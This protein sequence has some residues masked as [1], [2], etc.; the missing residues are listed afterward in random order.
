[1]NK[2]KIC[3]IIILIVNFGYILLTIRNDLSFF[4]FHS[5]FNETTYFLYIIL[6]IVWMAALL[7]SENVF[8]R[9]LKYRD[10]YNYKCYF[11]FAIILICVYL[12]SFIILFPGGWGNVGDEFLLYWAS[13]N[14]WIWPQQGALSGILM[15]I[16][17][18][19]WP[20]SWMIALIQTFV[21][22]L[23]FSRICGRLYTNNHKITS[24]LGLVLFCSLPCLS[25][26]SNYMRNWI[27]AICFVALMIEYA[28]CIEKRKV[29]RNQIIYMSLLFIFIVAI[30]TETKF[31]FFIYPF[32]LYFLISRCSCYW[33]NSKVDKTG[34]RI[35]GKVELIAVLI[36]FI[37]STIYSKF[38]GD[39]LKYR[40]LSLV[41]FVCPLS[42]ILADGSSNLKGLDGDIEN[43]DTV[44]P[45]SDLVSYPS[46]EL[47][48]QN[49][50]F[51]NSYD[52]CDRREQM[53]FVRSAIKIFVKNYKRYLY[54]R[55]RMVRAS[56]PYG[57]IQP[58]ADLEHIRI[59]CENND[60]NS[61][62]LWKD[63]DYNNPIRVK[64]SRI[65]AGHDIRKGF[66]KIVLLQY[67]YYIPLLA[68]LLTLIIS[69]IRKKNSYIVILSP[70][71]I[72]FI[73]LFFFVPNRSHIYFTVF[74]ITGWMIIANIVERIVYGILG[75]MGSFRESFIQ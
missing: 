28:L 26:N 29:N 57:G 47:F 75:L 66:R 21:T 10:N 67:N 52:D 13:K 18:M 3:L 19:F 23:I 39:Y 35:I 16:C 74:Y 11:V 68:I 65:L 44:F 46:D 4:D 2:R 71:L 8:Y 49:K 51:I 48:W 41:S 37:I 54:S 20:K 69:T 33:N 5:G 36:V 17:L 22:C 24:I 45:V 53:N 70:I 73:A 9:L 27:T 30:R 64:C 42:V 50:K 15:I 61:A 56:L 34:L 63:F 32:M 7:F 14:M 40:S 62:D 72:E 60:D 43:I 1:M 12:L 38:G 6:K 59:W 31:L 25:N 58:A 55:Y